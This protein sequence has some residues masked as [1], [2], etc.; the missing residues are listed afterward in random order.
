MRSFQPI[1]PEMLFSLAAP[2]S[3]PALKIPSS[4]PTSIER[5][6]KKKIPGAMA[7]EAL[8]EGPPQERARMHSVR[9]SPPPCAPAEANHFANSQQAAKTLTCA[10]FSSGKARLKKKH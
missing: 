4:I 10:W 8:E 6:D 1:R 7:V 3:P 2:P 5:E 9:R